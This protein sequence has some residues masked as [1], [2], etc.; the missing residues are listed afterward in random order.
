MIQLIRY[1]A[2]LAAL[3]VTAASAA[4]P[5]WPQALIDQRDYFT[6]KVYAVEGA[7]VWS[8]NNADDWAANSLIIEADNSLIVYDTGLSVEH[9]EAVMAQIRQYSDKPVKTIFYSHHH[10][11]H[12]NGTTGFVTAAAVAA[13]EVK[14]YAWDNFVSEKETEFGATG[15]SQAVRVMYY[16]G[17]ALPPSEHHHHGCCGSK[18]GGTPGYLAPTDVLS[19]DTTLL[20]DGVTIEAFY[21]GGEASSEFGLYLPAYK[22]VFV[23]DEIFPS[24]PN[25]YTLRGSKF[26]DAQGYMRAM[27]RVLSFDVEVMMGTHLVPIRGAAEIHQT[28]SRYRD[29]VQWIHDQAVRF[30]NK[31][32]NM[33]KLKQR[34]Q[35]VPSY[36]DNGLF[37]QEFY[38][39][40]E[41]IAPQMYA[42]YVGYFNGDAIEYRPTAPAEAARRTV[43]LMGGRDRVYSVAQQYFAEGDAQF[44]AELVTH[45]IV[46]D[47]SDQLARN[48]KAAAFRQ[49]GY[50]EIN[51]T[52][53]AWYLTSALE[54]EGKLQIE[55][56]LPRLKGLVM[57][58]IGQQSARDAFFGLRYR[59]KAE[60][61]DG[62][63]VALRVSAGD[64]PAFV[65]VIANGVLRIEPATAQADA[66]IALPRTAL[67]ALL[68]GEASWQAAMD[69][70]TIAVTGP[71][72]AVERFRQLIDEQPYMTNMAVH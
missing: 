4:A 69:D 25:I 43:E 66:A 64:E 16:L 48:L 33:A 30:I 29:L 34:F 57:S 65:A 44:A 18:Y 24:L 37:S 8:V 5:S 56:V 45:L 7:P 61:S 3:L 47:N 32:D 60:Q 67:N 11:D 15:P 35:E 23:A 46:L 71:R 54:L 26:R 51:T 49:L 50:A 20:I 62:S 27:D 55:R 13:G 68:K 1:G 2:A 19:E 17:S 6:P 36:L 63:R 28:V 21:T 10:P 70:G 40:L 14:I 72:G 22:T 31:G 39:A 58:G 59:V 42:G 9:G 12:Y 52:W 38:G 53:R 41:H